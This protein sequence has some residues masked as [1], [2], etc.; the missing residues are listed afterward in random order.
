MA[1][2]LYITANTKPEDLS[3]SKTVGRYFIQ[4]YLAYNPEDT[5]EE[6]DLYDGSIPMP[7][8]KVFNSRAKVVQGDAYNSLSEEDKQIADRITGLSDQF[9]AADKYVFAAPMWSILFPSKLKTYLD[10]IILDGKLITISPKKVQGLLNDRKRKMVYIQSSGGDYPIL[11]NTTF[12]H[13][14]R[15]LQDIFKFLGI[16][17]FDKVLVEGTDMPNIGRDK[18]IQM[19]KEEIDNMIKDF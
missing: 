17:D 11:F 12:N 6:L 8:Y 4:Q 10:C 15:Y 5:V 16:K 9:L 7:N 19:A 3:S 1:K 13:G 2:L 14:I 18:A